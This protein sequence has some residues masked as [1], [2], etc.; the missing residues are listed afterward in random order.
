MIVAF[1]QSCAYFP[2]QTPLSIICH[3]LIAISLCLMKLGLINLGAT[4]YIRDVSA[5]AAL[6]RRDDVDAIEI[7]TSGR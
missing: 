3:R 4:T 5:T 2:L 7:H 1:V 6:L